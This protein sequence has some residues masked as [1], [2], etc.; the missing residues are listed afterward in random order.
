MRENEEDLPRD[1]KIVKSLLK[2]MGVEYEPPSCLPVLSGRCLDGRLAKNR[3]RI[4]LPKT[5]AGADQD[6]SISPN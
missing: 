2:L 3:N 5:L 6:S 4:P 1:A